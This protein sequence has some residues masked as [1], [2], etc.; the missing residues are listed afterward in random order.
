MRSIGGE[1]RCEAKLE[2]CGFAVVLPLQAAAKVT[3]DV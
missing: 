1:L 3:I 2:G